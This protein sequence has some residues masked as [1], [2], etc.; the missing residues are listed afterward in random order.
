ME[1]RTTFMIAHRLSTVRRADLILVLDKGRLVQSGTHAELMLQDGGLYRQ[2]YELQN[3][4]RRREEEFASDVAAI[5][6]ALE[7][8]AVGALDPAGAEP[9][10]TD[11]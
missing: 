4:H 2:L 9:A 8:G 1:G 7:A 10:L 11:P 6:G 5:P 3:R